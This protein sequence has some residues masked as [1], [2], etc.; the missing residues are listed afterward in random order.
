MIQLP[1]LFVQ[2]LREVPALSAAVHETFNSFSPWLTQSGMP[3]FPGFTDHGPQHINDVLKTS[4]SLMSDDARSLVGPNDIAVLTLAVLL[5]DCGMHVTHDTFRAL[6]TDNSDPI[7]HGFG[8][9]PWAQLW[10]DFLSEARRF[11]DEKL[12]AIFGDRQPLRVDDLDISNINERECYLIGE[13]LRR[14]H[15][16][17]AHEIAIDG[18]PHHSGSRLEI[19][20]IDSEFKDM[21]GLVARSHGT[22]IRSTFDYIKN[23]YGLVSESR[24]VKLPF[25]MA[26]LRIADYVQVQSERALKSLLSV[27][28]LRSPISRQ[29]WRNHFAVRDVSMR[30]EDP[31]A[32]Y[33]HANPGDV[34]TFLRLDSLFKDIQREL[35]ETWATLGEVYGRQEELSPL[36]LTIRRVRSNFDSL[37]VFS[38]NVT[39]LPIRARFD[40]SGPDLLKLLVGP[41]YNY[42]YTV[43]IRELLQNAV[44]ACRELVDIY[45]VTAMDAT[46][47]AEPS[48]SIDIIE[49]DDGTAWVTISDSGVG[50]TVETVTNYFLV[51]GASFR[52]SEVWKRQHTDD[53]GFARV[54]RG[55]R[56]GVG[57][58]AAF[59]L[60]EEIT[61]KTRHVSHPASGGIEFTA[62]IDETSIELRRCNL[63]SSGTSIRIRVI[64]PKIVKSLRPMIFP[65]QLKNNG[66]ETI[67][68]WNEIDWFVQNEPKVRYS[69]DGFT[70]ET[71]YQPK[72]RYTGTYVPSGNRLVPTV[73]RP[74][75]G[76][77][78]IPNP[79]PYQA[80]YWKYATTAEHIDEDAADKTV[81]YLSNDDIVV[82]G[83]WVESLSD[84]SNRCFLDTGNDGDAPGPYYSVKRPSM[85]IFD[86][87]G[88]CPI[89][90]Q[91]NAIAFERMGVD[92]HIAMEV[93]QLHFAAV[94]DRLKSYGCM[95]A[96][97]IRLGID[98][99]KLPG[100][101]YKG[102]ILPFIATKAGIG[103]LSINNLQ[104]L[105]IT[106]LLLADCGKDAP[107]VSL[108]KLLR[109]NEAL[110]VRRNQR[111]I[112][113][114]LAWFRTIL[115]D[116]GSFGW[117]RGRLG[118]PAI[119][120]T[121]VGSIISRK[122]YEVVTEKGK[123]RRQII[124]SLVFKKIGEDYFFVGKKEMSNNLL[125]K[126]LKSV[127][128]SLDG[129]SEVSLWSGLCSDMDVGKSHLIDD[130]WCSVFGA[131][132]VKFG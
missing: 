56:F 36:G 40:A 132:I 86:P 100:I 77:R 84:Y 53:R 98:I 99:D 106:E 18:V 68:R 7:I 115:S 89:N 69:W 67:E 81:K 28:E 74:E 21:A 123:V 19:Q 72:V 121:N 34:K 125:E 105:G 102:Q 70:Q 76:W 20:G 127:Y 124:D 25:L 15:T 96:D 64:D 24:R 8:D 48:V 2:K 78:E 117:N 65:S 10:K 59:L 54:L 17:L 119:S 57:A 71:D 91:R 41:L 62:R 55:G 39:Y 16:R 126:R 120:P 31:E 101:Y 44:D 93:M 14:H 97:F 4:L 109:N 33:V 63:P 94:K 87:S 47:D 107:L 66:L 35:D 83:I 37:D 27:K 103:V 111:G 79:G 60:G 85:A 82:N 61:V 114:D 6:V 3:F 130:A 112:Q 122:Q 129:K 116:D 29:E 113:A 90:L 52:N 128:E 75:N 118:L 58:L 30:H 92:K 95:L 1:E 46:R 9:R 51:A 80:I 50:M 42:N 43:G 22:S 38:R 12:F 88:I 11:S 23:T 32:L 5:H 26:V 49:D 45:A 73:G 104:A 13:F 108:T 131:P 110:V